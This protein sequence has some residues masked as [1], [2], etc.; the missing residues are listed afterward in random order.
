MNNLYVIIVPQLS[1][2]RSFGGISS[3]DGGNFVHGCTLAANFLEQ[4]H[5]ATPNIKDFLN[6][7]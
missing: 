3:Q 2:I 1:L 5:L 7:R 6:L 4:V